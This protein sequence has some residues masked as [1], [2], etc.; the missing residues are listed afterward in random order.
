MPAASP[1]YGLKMWAILCSDFERLDNDRRKVVDKSAAGM[2]CSLFKV[3]YIIA[4][5]S[6]AAAFLKTSTSTLLASLTRFGRCSATSTS[7]APDLLQT[8]FSWPIHHF[9]LLSAAFRCRR[10]SL[11]GSRQEAST[12]LVGTG[13]LISIC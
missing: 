4:S 11:D 10:Y 7:E 12:G 3:A 1:V 8:P 5:G 2:C 9:T 6:K 13:S